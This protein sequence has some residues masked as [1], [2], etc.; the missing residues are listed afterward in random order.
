MSLPQIEV[1]ARQKLA[2]SI[3]STSTTYC[4]T[5]VTDKENLYT[6]TDQFVAYYLTR[7]VQFGEA[8]ELGILHGRE[9]MYNWWVSR[10]T[11]QNPGSFWNRT[12]RPMYNGFQSRYG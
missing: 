1:Y 9:W 6:S 5:T 2:G 4:N 8:Y 11:S 10:L 7:Q 12:L 3:C